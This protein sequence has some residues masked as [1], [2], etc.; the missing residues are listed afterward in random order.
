MAY[1]I[2]L[3]ELIPLDIQKTANIL[4]KAGSIAFADATRSAR[5]CSGILAMD[6][7]YDEA[8]SVSDELNAEGIGVFVMN[9][10]QM[11]QPER[12]VDIHNADCLPGCFSVE[13]VYGRLY[14]LAWSNIILISL[15]LVS[16]EENVIVDLFSKS[17]QKKHYR[18]RHGKFNYDYL[19]ARMKPRIVDNLGLLITD[20][21][22]CAT[23]AYG[24]RGVNAFLS[25]NELDQMD[26][27]DLNHFDKENLWLLQLIH[28]QNS[29]PEEG[30][31]RE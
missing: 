31:V 9:Q 28:L 10:G 8:K 29:P 5:N 27:G 16:D 3:N 2:L 23:Q 4:A 26:Y 12:P 6:L 11:V 7:P 17:P 18:I 30:N 24:N 13:D 14:S 21:V 1:A 19:G 25:G 15:G 20:I 22:R